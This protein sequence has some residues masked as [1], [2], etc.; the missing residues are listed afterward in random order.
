MAE[1]GAVTVVTTANSERRTGVQRG[2]QRCHPERSD[3][4]A[5]AQSKDLYPRAPERGPFTSFRAGPSTA[6]ASRA[7]LRMTVLEAPLTPHPNAGPRTLLRN[8]PTPNPIPTNWNAPPTTVSSRQPAALLL[9]CATSPIA[10]AVVP[11]VRHQ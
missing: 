3:G 10:R 5:G 6:P 7:P 8:A 2:S 9:A 11:R 1:R 4:A